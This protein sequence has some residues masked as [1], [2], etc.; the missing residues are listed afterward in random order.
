MAAS[1]EA[2]AGVSIPPGQSDQFAWDAPGVGRKYSPFISG[3]GGLGG[4]RGAPPAEALQRRLLLVDESNHN[5][6]GFGAIGLF[7]Q[8]NVAIEDTGLNHAV[9]AHLECEM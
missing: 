8:R 9:A 6:T 5:V 3:I 1:A 7:D 2:S 4:N